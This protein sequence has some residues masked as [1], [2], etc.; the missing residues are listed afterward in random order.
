MELTNHLLLGKYRFSFHD[1]N[2]RHVTQS[3]SGPGWDFNLA[4]KCVND[5]PDNE[6]FP[7]GVSLYAEAA[8]I[9]LAKFADYTGIEL[10]LPGSYDD[11]SGE[12]YFGLYVGETYDVSDVHL[13]FAERDGSR[14]L[15]IITGIISKSVL[16][17]SEPF[18]CTVW[19]EELPDHAYPK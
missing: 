11:A 7:L 15:L 17:K 18:E 13:R 2:F 19:A 6:L 9:P 4:A 3:Y 8:P 12:P 16:G 1:A 14:Y 5:D 10:D